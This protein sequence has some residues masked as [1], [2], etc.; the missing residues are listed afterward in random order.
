VRILSRFFGPRAPPADSPLREPPKK[1]E[2]PAHPALAGRTFR[3]VRGWNQSVGRIS[4]WFVPPLLIALF[5]QFFGSHVLEESLCGGECIDRARTINNL[6]DVLLLFAIGLCIGATIARRFQARRLRTA[7]RSVDQRIRPILAKASNQKDSDSIRSAI[8]SARRTF[9][10]PNDPA[11]VAHM[12]STLLFG[13]LWFSGV[14]TLLLLVATNRV[15]LQEG[16]FRAESGSYA[17]LLLVLMLCTAFITWKSLRV[18]RALRQAY[19]ELEGRAQ[20]ALDENVQR[21]ERLIRGEAA[22]VPLALSFRR[23][24]ASAPVIAGPP[25]WARFS[26]HP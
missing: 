1:F 15:F 19:Q 24:G 2:T 17:S 5:L 18:G 12:A 11:S 10:E 7:T 21:L 14:S 4:G 3:L 23:H 9:T 6:L 13:M 26:R 25:P 22:D 8:E 16:G 20:R